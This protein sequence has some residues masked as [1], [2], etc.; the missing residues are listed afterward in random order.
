MPLPGTCPNPKDCPALPTL[1]ADYRPKGAVVLLKDQ[2]NLKVYE[3]GKRESP[4]VL[5]AVY[6]IFGFQTNTQQVADKV[7]EVGGF[8]VVMPDFLRSQPWDPNN[9]PP[10]K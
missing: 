3:T 5:I 6:D 7:A 9:F 8:R 1:R 4:K 2:N 10:S